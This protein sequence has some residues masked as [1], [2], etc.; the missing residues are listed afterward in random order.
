MEIFE[1]VESAT[2]AEI[3]NTIDAA[4]KGGFTEH[5]NDDDGHTLCSKPDTS[6]LV[7]IFPDGSWE[8]QAIKEDGEMDAMSGQTATLLALYL[9][10][11]NKAIFSEEEK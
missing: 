7:D 11:D 9:H 5:V 3:L 4:T 8:Y 6:E 1:D 2:S 10:G